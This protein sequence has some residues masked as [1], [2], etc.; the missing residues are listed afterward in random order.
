M[1]RNQPITMYEFA[2]E[3]CRLN[4]KFGGEEICEKPKNK[5]CPVYDFQE[6]TDMQEDVRVMKEEIAQL[7]GEVKSLNE[8]CVALETNKFNQ[9]V[10]E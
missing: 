4:C 2:P 5:A 6:F 10:K 8:R 3:Y 9:G 1:T 7:I